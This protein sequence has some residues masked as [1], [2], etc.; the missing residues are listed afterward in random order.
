MWE[1]SK[2]DAGEGG[3][4][5]EGLSRSREQQM[6]RPRG[7]TMPSAVWATA[8]KPL[9]LE[10]MTEGKSGGGEADR[11]WGQIVRGL[12]GSGKDFV[13]YPSEWGAVQSSEQGRHDPTQ[14]LTGALWL[15]QRE[16]TSCARAGAGRPGQNQQRWSRWKMME[17]QTRVLTICIMLFFF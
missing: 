16:Q 13:F 12:G 6:Q 10:R 14:V 7:G 2:L 1:L 9:W 3:S 4:W 5:E 17:A 15:L 11:C 8:R